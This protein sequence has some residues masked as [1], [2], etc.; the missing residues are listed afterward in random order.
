MPNAPQQPQAGQPPPNM[1]QQ[2]LNSPGAAMAG[3]ALQNLTN[4]S[5][6]NYGNQQDPIQAYQRAVQARSIMSQREQGMKT[7]EAAEKRAQEKFDIE[8]DP[9]YM[10][11]KLVEQGLIDPEQMSFADYKRMGLAGRESSV[12][13]N[14]AL[15]RTQNPNASEAEASAALENIIRAPITYQTGAGATSVTSGVQPGGPGTQLTSPNQMIDAE[16]NLAGAKEGATQGAKTN[17]D[18]VNTGL[19]RA[20]GSQEA[21]LNTESM[22]KQ[23]ENF[24]NMLESGEL[25]TGMIDAWLL[26]TFGVGSEELA[27]MNN[28]SIMQGLKNLEIANLAPVT[29]NEFAKVMR[30]WADIGMSP[31]A[32]KGALKHA[33]ARTQALQERI[34]KDAAASARRVR[35]YGGQEA[36]DNL[37]QTNDFV[38]GVVAPPT[39]PATTQRNEDI[40]EDPAQ[41][42]F[43]YIPGQGLKPVGG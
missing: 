17:A 35:Q 11:N 42:E 19:E 18:Q 24:L 29:E 39:E 22:L 27:G 30:L 34:R 41:E 14:F 43:D 9:G 25:D 21:Y 33:I 15:W 4:T 13:R 28:E 12:E 38:R 5:L 10:Y 23:S 6:G 8:K 2:M 40:P 31:T 3:S 36:Y 1:A 26:N 20:W 32:N 7:A 16:S 37:L